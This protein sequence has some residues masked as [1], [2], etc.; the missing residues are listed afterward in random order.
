MS[1]AERCQSTAALEARPVP[2]LPGARDFIQQCVPEPGA[3]AQT[4]APVSVYPTAR[5]GDG[6]LPQIKRAGVRSQR[7]LWHMPPNTG[8]ISGGPR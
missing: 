2:D 5:S 7:G 4:G 6:L 1:P 3:S 8:G